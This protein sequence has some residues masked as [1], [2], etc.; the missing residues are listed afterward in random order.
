MG[1]FTIGS[2]TPAVIRK[3]ENRVNDT[4]M[5]NEW[6]AEAITEICSDMQL[7]NDLVEL[8][9]TGPVYNLTIGQQEYPEANLVVPNDVN[10]ATADWML[11]I[12]YP[13]NN[14]RIKL[15]PSHYQETDKFIVVNS[16]PVKWYRFSTNLGVYPVPNQPYQT[17]MRY[18]KRHPI[19]YIT[20][21]PSGGPV[22]DPTTPILLNYTWTE[23]IRLSAAQKGFLELEEYEKSDAIGK[24]LRGDPDD[25]KRSP[26]LLYGKKTRREQESW[27]TE[28]GL[29]PMIHSYTHWPR[30]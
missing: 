19:M 22:V 10:W 25:P 16:L 13:S 1:A 24:L 18:L 27:R 2:L 6:I 8:E 12:D 15:L 28:Q 7:R 11:W 9:S 26:G 20:P 14:I 29:K 23:V 4:N 3:V 17:Q 21:Q 5:V 30:G